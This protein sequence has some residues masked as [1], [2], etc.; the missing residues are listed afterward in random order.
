MPAIRQLHFPATL[1]LTESNFGVD[2]LRRLWALTE[3][4]R[5]LISRGGE[6]RVLFS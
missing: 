4:E 1:S 6:L 5:G 3:M 2:F